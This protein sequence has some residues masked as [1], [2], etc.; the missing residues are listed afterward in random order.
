MKKVIT[1][2]ILVLSLFLITG[3]SLFTKAGSSPEKPTTKVKLGEKQYIEQQKRIKPTTKVKLG[4]KQYIEQQK[5]IKIE[6]T[7]DYFIITEK[8]KWDVPD[9]GP[10]TTVSFAIDIP[11]TMH[12]DGKDYNGHY[13]LNNYSES[14]MDKNPKYKLEVTNLTKNYDTQVIITKK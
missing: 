10:G 11:Y 6:N 4:E 9:Y 2:F 13:M 14:T 8:V 1:L 12:V 7:G 5:R 3:C